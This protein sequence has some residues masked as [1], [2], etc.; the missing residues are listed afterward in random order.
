MQHRVC[1]SRAGVLR[2]IN[3]G[4]ILGCLGL[5]RAGVCGLVGKAP[6]ESG[7]LRI[8]H[9]VGATWGPDGWCVTFGCGLLPRKEGAAPS[10]LTL[11]T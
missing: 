3:F 2:A 4:E 6:L 9:G 8:M 7:K 10:R 5:A 11:N 1:A